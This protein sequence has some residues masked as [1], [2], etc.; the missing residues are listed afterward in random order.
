MKT[1]SSLGKKVTSR[2]TKGQLVAMKNSKIIFE[3]MLLMA[4]SRNFHIEGVL[5]YSLR[6][7]P[8]SLATI[9]GDLIKT[10]KSKLLQ[11][12]VNEANSPNVSDL[13]DG[14][15]AC[16]LDAFAILQTLTPI[17]DSFGELSKQLLVKI[18]NFAFGSKCKRV[19]FVCDQYPQQSIK[20]LERNGRSAQDFRK[21]KIYSMAQKVLRQGKKFLSCGENKEELMKFIYISWMKADLVLLRGI[22]VI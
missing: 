9:D 10:Q 7:F 19:D 8:S 20:S 1:F 4:K 11:A 6:P 2:S 3:R 17:R 22:E 16:V 13:P 15:N 14:D 21:V 18:V 5:K 12:V